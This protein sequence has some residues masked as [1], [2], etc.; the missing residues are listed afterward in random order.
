[1]TSVIFSYYWFAIK[2]NRTSGHQNYGLVDQKLLL[3]HGTGPMAVTLHGVCGI[4]EVR[5][6]VSWGVWR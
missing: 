3:P 2:M 4:M 1:M 5:Y 6:S